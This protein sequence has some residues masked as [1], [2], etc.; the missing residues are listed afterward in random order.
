MKPKPQKRNSFFFGIAIDKYQSASI[1]NLNNA[2]LDVE[3]IIQVLEERYGFKIIEPL[4]DE[5]ATRRN[6]IEKI[7][8]LAYST[9]NEDNLVIYFA[10][11]GE[12]HPKTKKGFWIPCDASSSVGDYIPNSSIIDALEGIEAKHILLISD[13]CFSGTFLTQMR[14]LDNSNHYSKLDSDNSRWLIASGREEKV[15]DG[16]AGAGS[17]FAN[18]FST[19]LEKNQERYLSVGEINPI[20][21][22]EVGLSTNQQPIAGHI[23]NTGHRGGQLIF[24]LKE[25][26][27]ID[28][29]QPLIHNIENLSEEAKIVVPY[30]VALSLSKIGVPQKSIF[31]FFNNGEEV[32]LNR[33]QKNEHFICS[34]FT[35]S[36]LSDYIPEM[37]EIDTNTFVARFDGYDQ[38]TEK[39]L[40]K[41]VWA[42]VTYQKTGTLETPFMAICRTGGRMV[43]FSKTE[44]GLFNNLITWGKTEAEAKALML[45]ELFNEGKIKFE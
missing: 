31:A 36:E 7:N 43:A 9:T 33:F 16:V 30:E 28:K 40:D 3:R 39:M 22:K 17:P 8:Q 1:P 5:C 10:G 12:I 11:H 19:I 23:E 44:D 27:I 20:I 4:F 26:L 2:K 41:Y 37:I 14:S 35:S 25:G 34:A 21:L 24:Q 45:I 6:I 38:I 18:C 13:S 32:V 29:K 42:E 15:S